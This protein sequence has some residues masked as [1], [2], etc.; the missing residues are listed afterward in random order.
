[1]LPPWQ[2]EGSKKRRPES[3]VQSGEA[4]K[5]SYVAGGG[6]CSSIGTLLLY[7]TS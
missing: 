7:G 2:A 1:M 4:L 3:M 6:G 5:Q